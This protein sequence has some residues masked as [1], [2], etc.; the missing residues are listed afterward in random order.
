MAPLSAF[1][2]RRADHTSFHTTSAAP[3]AYRGDPFVKASYWPL[4]LSKH[5]ELR[6]KLVR[7]FSD[8]QEAYQIRKSA[9]LER[10]GLRETLSA[11]LGAKPVNRSAG[12]ARR[13]WASEGPDGAG[14]S[15]AS[16]GIGGGF[17][18]GIQRSPARPAPPN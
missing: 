12:K 13:Y 11:P 18:P 15:V 2:A 7:F 3:S 4:A 16:G 5:A 1:R 8:L 10:K 9:A 6:S 14:E 17:E